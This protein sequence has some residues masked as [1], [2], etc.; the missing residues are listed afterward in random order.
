LTLNFHT[1]VTLTDSKRNI[2]LSIRFAI[3]VGGIEPPSTND[4]TDLGQKSCEL[5]QGCCAAPALHFEGTQRQLLASIDPDL[6]T[7]MSGWNRLPDAVRAAITMLI[8]ANV[9]DLTD[10]EKLPEDRPRHR[11]E[12]AIQIA[13]DCRYVIQGC[14]REE[15]WQ[16]AD[17]EFY[18][19]IVP[20]L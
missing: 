16:D 10:P 12:T 1:S 11:E 20:H 8:R 14:L 3:W 15:E 7:V 17:E 13:R 6:Q 4:G 9:P 19:L 2:D 18:D 5:C